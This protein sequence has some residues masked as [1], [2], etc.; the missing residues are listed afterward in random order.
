MTIQDGI[1]LEN[2]RRYEPFWGFAVER[3]LAALSVKIKFAFSF[4]HIFPVDA[5]IIRHVVVYG[6]ITAGIGIF[7]LLLGFWHYKRIHL[8]IILWHGARYW[9]T[10]IILGLVAGHCYAL[11]VVSL[12]GWTVN[13]VAAIDVIGLDFGFLDID[14]HGRKIF[15]F[16]AFTI[17]SYHVDEI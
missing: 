4:V 13:V 5:I 17:G 15:C 11:N 2:N 14:F 16:I 12:T 7:Q 6:V 10:G 9:I 1:R 8:K 3:D